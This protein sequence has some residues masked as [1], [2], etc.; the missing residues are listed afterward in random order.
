[1]CTVPQWTACRAARVT[2]PEECSRWAYCGAP[3]FLPVWSR[4]SRG[5]S[6]PAPEPPLPRLRVDARLLAADGAPARRTLQ[7]DLAGTQHAVLVLAPA[8]GVAVTSCSEL[9]GPPR[10]GPAWG[11]RRTYFVTLHHARDP[12]AW[13]LECVLEGSGGA[14]GGWVQV[15]A[16]GHAM[17]GPRRLAD[18]HARLLQAAPPHV[19]VTGWGVDLHILDL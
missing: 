6:M 16:A 17:F 9:A 12:H 7:L 11:A 14:A 1:M 3:Y 2:S 8:E 19:A 13:R 5:Y 15:S 18:S 10:E 4:V